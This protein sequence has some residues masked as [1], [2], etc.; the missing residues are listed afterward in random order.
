MCPNESANPFLHVTPKTY[1]DAGKRSDKRSPTVI[2][3]ATLSDWWSTRRSVR[4][5]CE[6]SQYGTGTTGA[7]E[8]QHD[9][10]E[11]NDVTAASRHDFTYSGAGSSFP[12]YVYAPLFLPSAV[13]FPCTRKQL[14]RRCR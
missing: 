6:F 8:E 9:K 10:M 1:G 12:A 14:F 11:N 13:Q 4:G 5:K 2:I 7:G 3:G